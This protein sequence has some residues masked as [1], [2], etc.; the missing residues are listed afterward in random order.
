MILS[1]GSKF[2]QKPDRIIFGTS[3]ISNTSMSAFGTQAFYAK[4]A[5]KNLSVTFDRCLK[6]EKQINKVT[7]TGLFQLR[8]LAKIKSFLYQRDL[9]KAIYA[10]RS[11]R[12]DHF[13]ALYVDVNQSLLAHLQLVHN[14]AATFLRTFVGV[15]T[16]L[17]FSTQ[18]IGFQFVHQQNAE[19]Y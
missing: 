16:L 5:V 4:P 14:A 8:L 1:S 19:V 7:T 15:R 18:C 6:F 17:L 12:Q 2:K 9:E 3:I 13:N 11:L 10:F